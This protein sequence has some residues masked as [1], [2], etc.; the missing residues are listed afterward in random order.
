[1][2]YFKYHFSVQKMTL[3]EK[4]AGHQAARK[5]GDMRVTGSSSFNVLT[6]IN[7]VIRNNR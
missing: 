4:V 7:S 2:L 1:M 5:V 6:I 3:T